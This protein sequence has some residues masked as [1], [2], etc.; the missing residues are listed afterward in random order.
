MIIN[1]QNL[2][3]LYTGFRTIFNDAFSTAESQFERVAMTVPS[4]T[5]QE[6]YAWLG[7][8]PR[9]RE[10]VGE[11]TVQNLSSHDYAIKNRD[12][13]NTIGVDRNT[14]EDDTYGVYRPAVQMLGQESK[15]HPDEL[16]FPLLSGGLGTKGYDGQYFF[17]TDHPV[18]D[19][20]NSEVSVSNFQG[21]AGTPWFLLD[22]SKPV[23]PFIFQKRREYQFVAMDRVD[24]EGVFMRREFRYGVDARANAGY[25]LWQLAYA[26][27]Q[28]LNAANYGGARAAMMSM[29][30]DGGK[31]LNIR[32]TLLVVPPSLE[33]AALEV[34]QAERLANGATN[35]YR[36]TAQLLVAPWLA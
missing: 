29:K 26:S 35:V 3:N 13:E 33:Q 20:D 28:T 19:K 15:T 10:W 5:A 25:A 36:N 1:R 17:D 22:V 30:A 9:F 2:V 34:L 7:A 21:G 32:P 11:R 14:I 8:L 31:P 18:R 16:V 6:T 4:S 23:K 12:F 27:Q 24:D